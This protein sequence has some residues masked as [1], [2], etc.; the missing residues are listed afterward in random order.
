MRIVSRLVRSQRLRTVLRTLLRSDLTGDGERVEIDLT[1]RGR[2]YDQFDMYEKSHFE[3]Y[4]FACSFLSPDMFVGDFACGTGY[5]TV[6]MSQYAHHIFGC[7]LNPQVVNAMKKRYRQTKNVKFLEGD[8]LEIR[9]LPPLDLI[10]SFEMIEHFQE[11]LIPRV[12]G[13]F[14]ELLKSGGLL[15]FSTPYMQP[16]TGASMKHH[17]TFWIDES[18]VHVWAE[19]SGF[20]ITRFYYQNYESHNIAEMLDKKDFII[21]LC[22]KARETG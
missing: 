11:Q 3:R 13:K 10:A 15:L 21:C 22:S 7:D 18:R 1:D 14:N 20:N 17:K 16:R 9:D 12:F 19:Q 8:I 4:Q 6:M 5:G 2:C